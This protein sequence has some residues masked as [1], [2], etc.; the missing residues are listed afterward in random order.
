MM[1]KTTVVT[2]LTLIVMMV[3]MRCGDGDD[4]GDNDKSGV[5]SDGWL[6]Q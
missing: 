4:H 1:M 2:L 5:D 3:T 6:W